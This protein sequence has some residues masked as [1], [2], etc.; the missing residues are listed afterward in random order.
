MKP[1]NLPDSLPVS[2]RASYDYVCSATERRDLIIAALID[3]GPLTA[4]QVARKLMVSR[5]TVLKDMDGVEEYLRTRGVRLSRIRGKGCVATG[6]EQAIRSLAVDILS[7]ATQGYSLWGGRR[8]P[9]VLPLESRDP[10]SL[11]TG[12]YVRPIL[13][14]VD[15]HLL[16][17]VFAAVASACR[18][19]N[20]PLDV[21]DMSGVVWHVAV[22]LGRFRRGKTVTIPESQR[23]LFQGTVEHEAASILAAKLKDA[24]AIK[25]PEDEIG[26]F[27]VQFLSSRRSG[28][29][30]SQNIAPPVDPEVSSLASR[31]VVLAESL[32]GVQLAQDRELQ[33]GLAL[34]L[35]PI[36]ERLRF[37]LPL[38]N[39]LLEDIKSKYPGIF[40]VAKQCSALLAEK[41]GLP[42]PDDEV[43][44]LA[45][46]LGAALERR[47]SRDKRIRVIL[48][49][50]NGIGAAQ[51]LASMVATHIPEVEIVEVASHLDVLG[52]ILRSG[53]VD[54]IV[55]T[56][57]LPPLGPPVIMVPPIVDER[58]IETLRDRLLGSTHENASSQEG[59]AT[60]VVRHRAAN[61]LAEA[62]P[63][64]RIVLDAPCGTRVEAVR[65][66]GTL[67]VEAGLALPMYVDRMVELLETLGPY[68]VVAPGVALPHA[69][70]EDDVSGVGMSMVRLKEPVAFGS[71]VNDP[72]DLVFALCSV[73]LVSHLKALTELAAV[74]NSP[75]KLNG[76]RQVSAPE[77]AAALLTGSG[78]P[79]GRR[80]KGGGQNEKEDPGSL[81]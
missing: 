32:L 38:R 13:K 34:H 15:A 47:R 66:A 63:P 29:V 22:F 52:Q 1:L 80:M 23:L 31:F 56:V 75:A 20:L 21:A 50:G 64:S 12:S 28:I 73:D 25:V 42:V 45:M 69:R 46:Y 14:L 51:L 57:P 8:K 36:A 6:S 55:S 77:G 33:L 59:N 19:S 65:I 7:R 26:Y 27:T 72:V 30:L 81:R 3:K 44:Y 62:L 11:R 61:A 9:G 5:N 41:F 78:G 54:Y 10:L 71:V 35:A 49:C 18:A 39:P 40:F 43:G 74:V 16:P 76:L 60:R 79:P 53:P 24:L 68:I 37:G 70:P 48:A 17:Q 4:A 67:L 2:E 58:D